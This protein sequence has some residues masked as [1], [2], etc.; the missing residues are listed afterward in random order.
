[1]IPVDNTH[2]DM[3][4]RYIALKIRTKITLHLA[5]ND[6]NMGMFIISLKALIE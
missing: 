5:D 3:L 1:M 6:I 2:V 4:K